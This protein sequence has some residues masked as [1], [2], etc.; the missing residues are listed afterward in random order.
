M[1]PQKPGG[2]EFKNNGQ[3]QSMLSVMIFHPI[4]LI[5]HHMFLQNY[6]NILYINFLTLIYFYPSVRLLFWTDWGQF[7]RIES[8]G[9]DGSNR[10]VIV[11][12]KLYW[13]NGLALDRPAKRL[14]FADARLDYIDY[15]NYDGS[16]RT[17]LVADDHVSVIGCMLPP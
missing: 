12:T 6:F 16:G 14:Y 17:Q 7:P 10:K 5:F 11:S 9:M 2:H 1:I 4:V 3:V 8:S 13:P 15:C